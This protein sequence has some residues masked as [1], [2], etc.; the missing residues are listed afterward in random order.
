MKF[1]IRKDQILSLIHISPF[2]VND[3][4]DISLYIKNGINGYIVKND[5]DIANVLKE[6]LVSSDY[7][8][9]EM[10]EKALLT[11]KKYFYFKAYIREFE[12]FINRVMEG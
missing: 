7:E 4:G 12:M 5:K 6:V 8:R 11:A 10:R 2:I 9:S 3:T 1:L